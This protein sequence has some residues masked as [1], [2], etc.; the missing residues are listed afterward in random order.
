M[1]D[2]NVLVQLCHPTRYRDVQEWFRSLLLSGADSLEIL[3]SV[4]ADYELRRVL[5]RRGA[6][7]SLARLDDLTRSIRYIPVTAENVRRAAE[8]SARLAADG[9]HVS[10][11]DSLMAAQ[12]IA[13]G[14]VLVTSDR[15]LQKVPGLTAKDWSE[16][17]VEA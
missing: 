3:I 10:D 4:L 6:N 16:L 11:V 9:Q 1:L 5:I 7:A 13:E 14:A 15:S 2:T 8:I 12:A 17:G